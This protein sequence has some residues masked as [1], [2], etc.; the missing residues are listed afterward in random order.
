LGSFSLSSN[1]NPRRSVDG[2]HYILTE[3][4]LCTANPFKAEYLAGE[5][6]TEGGNYFGE[7]SKR[8]ATLQC[9]KWSGINYSSIHRAS[10]TMTGSKK[11]K[12]CLDC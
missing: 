11:A 7:G 12:I 2:S 9:S 6:M 10:M 3:N 5:V 1:S 4:L 8:L